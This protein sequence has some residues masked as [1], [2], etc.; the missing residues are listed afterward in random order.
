M[1]NISQFAT[2]K[3][4]TTTPRYPF[5]HTMTHNVTT[6]LKLEDLASDPGRLR[7]RQ[8]NV[9]LNFVETFER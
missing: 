8:H 7:Y 9:Y 2:H 4:T 1:A 3:T 5:H 6:S